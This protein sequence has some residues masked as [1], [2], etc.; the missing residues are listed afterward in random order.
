[1]SFQSQLTSGFRQQEEQQKMM[2]FGGKIVGLT[3]R[4]HD[5]LLA[6]PPLGLVPPHLAASGSQFSYLYE[7]EMGLKGL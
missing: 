6:L 5:S 3:V 4:R 7:E 1:M 2:R